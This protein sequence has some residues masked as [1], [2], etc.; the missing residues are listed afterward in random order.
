MLVLYNLR[1]SRF[2]PVI[3][4]AYEEKSQPPYNKNRFFWTV[5]LLTLVIIFGVPLLV[6]F[7]YIRWILEE[8]MISNEHIVE[9]AG[10]WIPAGLLLTLG[11]LMLWTDPSR[12]LD[13]ARFLVGRTLYVLIITVALGSALC[14]LLFFCRFHYDFV[15]IFCLTFNVAMILTE[16]KI[17]LKTRTISDN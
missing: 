10:A 9:H 7:S 11:C 12:S 3:L 17:Y 2:K 6:C 16:W 1:P 15:V 13:Q 5:Y 8:V 4:K 14:L